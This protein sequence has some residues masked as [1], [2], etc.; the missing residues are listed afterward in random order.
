MPPSA[1]TNE[2]FGQQDGFP[3]TNASRRRQPPP[4]L[5]KPIPHYRHL[6]RW[7]KNEVPES[8]EEQQLNQDLVILRRALDLFL[9]NSMAEAEAIMAEGPIPVTGSLADSLYAT[10]SPSSAN[11]A[12]K[13]AREALGM[14]NGEKKS[15][16]QHNSNNNTN[17]NG[18]GN[19]NNYG[20]DDEKK[21][22]EAKNNAALADDESS[23]TSS[24]T[25]SIK[26]GAKAKPASSSGSS[27]G[28]KS[29]KD[30][31]AGMYYELGKAIIQGLKALVTFDPEEIEKGMKAFEQAI[32]TADKQRKNSVLGLGSVKAVGAFV[33]GTIGAGSF[34]GMTRVQK[35][36]VSFFYFIRILSSSQKKKNIAL[37]QNL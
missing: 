10:A 3:A 2:A 13:R 14:T 11:E 15:V 23:V 6:V 24:S 33:V 8:I 20:G 22:Q 27:S 1:K 32:K 36:A 5:K 25:P 34:R 21:Q 35:H 19:G 31:S 28:R 9:N 37:T 26:E 17:G 29:T 7:N 16:S 18:N 12:A 30:K 4:K